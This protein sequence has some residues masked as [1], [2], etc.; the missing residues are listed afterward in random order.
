MPL[1]E[2]LQ[3]QGDWLFRWR[4]YV[5]LALVPVLAFALYYE[6]IML[7]EEEYLMGVFGAAYE[8]WAAATPAFLPRWR[9]WR[10]PSMPF[11]VRTVLKREYSGLFGIIAMFTVIEAIRA[12]VLTGSFRLDLFWLTLFAAGLVVYLALIALKKKTRLLHVEGR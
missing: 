12:R 7:A 4:S 10:P 11:S 3:Q 5:P 9:A 6:R 1:K 2:E 8:A